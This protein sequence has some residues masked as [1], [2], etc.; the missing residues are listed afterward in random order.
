MSFP[1]AR[2]RRCCFLYFF[3]NHSRSSGDEK[4]VGPVPFPVVAAR[5]SLCRP[6]VILDMI[7]QP[8]GVVFAL[9]EATKRDAKATEDAFHRA[10][11]WRGT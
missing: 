5:V 8:G 7:E 11:E 2:L 9:D 4:A 6:V 1:A 10:D 3:G